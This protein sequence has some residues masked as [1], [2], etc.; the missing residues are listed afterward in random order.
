MA[1]DHW[2]CRGV[3]VGV[4]PV[5][6]LGDLSEALSESR[7]VDTD[8]GGVAFGVRFGVFRGIRPLTA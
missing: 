4:V 2:S 8:T 5:V 1:V 7:Q 3:Y 6:G